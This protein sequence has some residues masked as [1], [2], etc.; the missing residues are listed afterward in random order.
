MPATKRKVLEGNLQR[1]I[2]ARREDSEEVE[3]LSDS[4]APSVH[5]NNEEGTSDESDAGEEDGDEGEGDSVRLPLDFSEH[6]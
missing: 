3:D 1:R 4:E 6:S 2:R 5:G